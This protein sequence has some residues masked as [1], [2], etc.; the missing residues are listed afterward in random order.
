MHKVLIVGVLLLI[1]LL[2]SVHAQFFNCTSETCNLNLTSS[3]WT[4]SFVDCPL[5]PNFLNQTNVTLNVTNTTEIII[6]VTTV[7]VTSLECNQSLFFSLVEDKFN[8]TKIYGDC[9]EEIAT[10]TNELNSCVSITDGLRLQLLNY[11]PSSVCNS[12]LAFLE[13]NIT[14]S[15]K[16][17]TEAQDSQIVLFLAGLGVASIVIWFLFMRKP[18]LGDRSNVYAPRGEIQYDVKKMD[19]VER[20]LDLNKHNQVVQQDP[21][22]IAS[23]VKKGV[24]NKAGRI[25][26]SS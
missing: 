7:N 1:S 21:Q 15:Q 14:R 12:Q 16:I 24:V 20:K 9:R 3:L 2:P 25:R 8:V 19:D 18:S 5:R 17:I 22:S 6:N 26:K 13:S 10:T 11:T 4:C 23:R